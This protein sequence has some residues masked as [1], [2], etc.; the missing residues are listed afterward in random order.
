MGAGLGSVLALGAATGFGQV[1]TETVAASQVAQFCVPP[2]ENPDAHRFY[3]RNEDGWSG[4]NG[5]AA[6]ACVMQGIEEKRA[7]SPAIDSLRPYRTCDSRG[8]AN[9]LSWLKT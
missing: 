7:L 8:R 2:Q 4:P 1:R 6:F 3:C 5:A 9:A